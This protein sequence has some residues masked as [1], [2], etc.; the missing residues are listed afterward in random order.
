MF[1]F[2]NDIV[3]LHHFKQQIAKIQQNLKH[4]IVHAPTS[5][6]VP[7][8]NSS[9]HIPPVHSIRRPSNGLFNLTASTDSIVTAP[10]PIHTSIVS[11]ESKDIARYLT[12]ADY[13]LLKAILASGGLNNSLVDA[14]KLYVDLM[15]KRANM[16]TTIQEAI[17]QNFIANKRYIYIYIAESLG[18][19]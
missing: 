1:L 6:S 13:Y 17:L 9:Q 11:L 4:Q 10:I 14:D 8:V 19:S 3:L 18:G 7:F 15:T 2:N 5:K 16:V 12:L